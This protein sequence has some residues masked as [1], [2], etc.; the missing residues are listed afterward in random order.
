G[1]TRQEPVPVQTRKHKVEESLEEEED[2]KIAK[3][4]TEDPHILSSRQTK[5][6]KIIAPQQTEQ[7]KEAIHAQTTKTHIL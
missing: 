1:K 6:N 7:T 2:R 5:K 4:K 3:C